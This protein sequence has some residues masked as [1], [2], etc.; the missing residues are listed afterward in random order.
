MRMWRIWVLSIVALFVAATGSIR[1]V[2]AIQADRLI[3]GSGAAPV[4]NAVLMVEGDRITAVGAV[5]G[6]LIPAGARVIDLQGYTIL[7]RR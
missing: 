5:G 2:I 1:E 7:P 6:L 4:E 3:D